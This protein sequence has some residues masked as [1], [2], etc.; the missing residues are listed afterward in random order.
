MVGALRGLVKHNAISHFYGMGVGPVGHQRS[1]ISCGATQCILFHTELGVMSGPGADDV[2]EI[3]RALRTSSSVSRR[4]SLKGSRTVLKSLAGSAG[5]KW[6]MRALFCSGRV[7]APSS[8][9]KRGGGRPTANFLAV[10][11]V[12]GVAEARK[13]DQCS[14]LAFLIPLK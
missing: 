8:C 13:E 1:W 14:L 9:R 5:K 3:A 10:Q 2:E 12:C 6:F 7:M 4:K 11:T